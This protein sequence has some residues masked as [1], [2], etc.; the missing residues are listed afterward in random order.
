MY[1]LKAREEI[2][3]REDEEKRARQKR[4]DE[5]RQGSR[6]SSSPAAKEAKVRTGG[7]GARP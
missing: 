2:W 4:S 1:A 5:A 6:Q 7:I 3:K